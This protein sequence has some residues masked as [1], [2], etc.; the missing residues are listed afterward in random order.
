MNKRTDEGDE[1]G[2]EWLNHLKHD[3]FKYEYLA[4][5]FGEDYEAA[6]KELQEKGSEFA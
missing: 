3:L 2:D 1:G 4:Q 5:N 6:K